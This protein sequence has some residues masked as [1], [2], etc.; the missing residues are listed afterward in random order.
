[1]EEEEL[2]LTS[3]I[4]MQIELVSESADQSLTIVSEPSLSLDLISDIKL[5][6]V[7]Y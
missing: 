4:S 7:T 5:E 6:E 1:M 3:E 2:I